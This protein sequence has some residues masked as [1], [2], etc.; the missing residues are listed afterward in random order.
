MTA[1]T[2]PAAAQEEPCILDVLRIARQDLAA[3]LSELGFDEDDIAADDTIK[4]IEAAIVRVEALKESVEAFT[5]AEATEH[6]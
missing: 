6:R 1:H 4:M 5:H 3:A 2:Q